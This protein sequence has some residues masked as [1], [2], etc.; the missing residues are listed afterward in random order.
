MTINIP[1]HFVDQYTSNLANLLEIKG[2][3]LRPYVTVSSHVG[4]GAVAVDQEGPLE[5]LEVIGRGGPMPRMDAATDRRWVYPVDYELSQRVDTFDL[6]RTILPDPQSRQVQRAARSA[7]RKTDEV[8]FGKFFDVAK[9]GRSG[10]V[11]EVFDDTNHRVDAALGAAAD[12][13]L[14]VDKIIRARRILLQNNV[15]L[16]QEQAVMAIHPY[17]E[18]DLLRQTQII[19]TD[20]LVANGGAPILKDGRVSRI[21][22]IDII[23]SML[24][25]TDANYRL[26]PMWVP[27]GMHLGVWS[28]LKVKVSERADISGTPYQVYS[29]L[30]IGA[31]RI[32]PGRVIKIECQEA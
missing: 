13:G 19:N 30:T 23:T 8:I 29:Q 15:D 31:T 22:G 9:T 1:T 17:Q 32:E 26:N 6:L 3:K 16:E 24:V 20:Y 4:E 12:T 14:N 10:E 28:D 5:M 27:S 7:A 2:G 11:N 18:E 25:P 21:A